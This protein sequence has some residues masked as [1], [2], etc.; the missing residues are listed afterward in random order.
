LGCPYINSIGCLIRYLPSHSAMQ[1]GGY[2]KSLCILHICTVINNCHLMKTI[3]QQLPIGINCP[4]LII[5]NRSVASNS[6]RKFN[7]AQP[8]LAPWIVQ[9]RANIPAAST[10]G[11]MD[12]WKRTEK[13]HN[14][15]LLVAL[16]SRHTTPL[17]RST[18]AIIKIMYIYMG[19]F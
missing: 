6:V 19:R 17:R 4:C 16:A 2:F 7:I 12:K 5:F 15:F 11:H 18:Y 13:T 1:S 10:P 9:G 3:F 14:I 8:T